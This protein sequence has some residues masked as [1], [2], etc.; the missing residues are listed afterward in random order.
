[1]I[2]TRLSTRKYYITKDIFYADIK[3]MCDNCRMYNKPDSVY[4]AC[5]QEVD[6][7]VLQRLKRA[8]I[9]GLPLPMSM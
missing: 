7:F 3:R 9:P 4:Y 2:Q 6:D 8:P 5:A 1:M